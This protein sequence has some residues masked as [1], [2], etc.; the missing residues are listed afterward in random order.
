LKRLRAPKSKPGELKV[1]WGK[2]PHDNP[3]I[4]YSWG[5]GCSRTDGHLLHN[6]LTSR[7]YYAHDLA[8]P[9]P[10]LLDELKERGYDITTLKF[11]IRKK[12]Q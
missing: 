6:A 11:Y 1:Q 8:H 5:D 3:D 12:A 10:S 9:E 4:C 7:R 2:L